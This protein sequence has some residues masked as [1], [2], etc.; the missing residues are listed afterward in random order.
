MSTIYLCRCCHSNS[1]H[2]LIFFEGEKSE[3]RGKKIPKKTTTQEH[4]HVFQKIKREERR[5][6]TK[7]D[8]WKLLCG[9]RPHEMLLGE[10]F[11]SEEA[12]SHQP[13][14]AGSR[15]QCKAS[16]S[17]PSSVSGCANNAERELQAVP[18]S[19]FIINKSQY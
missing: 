3:A 15:V 19:D 7:L 9:A 13:T 12:I 2:F 10:F 1:Q 16:A 8:E 17:F 11:M 6:K 18:L 4:E 5:L 14:M